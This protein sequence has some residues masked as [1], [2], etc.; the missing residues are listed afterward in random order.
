MPKEQKDRSKKLIPHVFRFTGTKQAYAQ[1]QLSS[2][3]QAQSEAEISSNTI[4]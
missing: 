1:N 3:T 2:W 4:L